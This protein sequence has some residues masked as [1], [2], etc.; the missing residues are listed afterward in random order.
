MRRLLVCLTYAAAL[1]MPYC[2]ISL[3]ADE[4]SKLLQENQAL[5]NEKM[6]LEAIIRIESEIAQ[7]KAPGIVTAASGESKKSVQDKLNEE[8][9]KARDRGYDK[10]FHESI[11]KNG[12]ER[13]KEEWKRN[14]QSRSTKPDQREL[15]CY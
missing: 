6:A 14:C 12:G 13:L 1:A 10:E 7:V 2:T 5:R 9:K 4:T 11:R 8:H 3:A 15:N